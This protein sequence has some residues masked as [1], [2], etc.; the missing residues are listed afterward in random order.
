M[1]CGAVV[2]Q[3]AATKG[4]NPVGSPIV[5]TE[6]DRLRKI[7][8]FPTA[9]AALLVLLALVA[10]A[11]AVGDQHTAPA[12]RPRSPQDDRLRPPASTTHRGVAGHGARDRPG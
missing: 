2:C 7:N 8:W 3:I 12:T 11:D 9:T 5:P 1:I 4:T 10:V 6:I